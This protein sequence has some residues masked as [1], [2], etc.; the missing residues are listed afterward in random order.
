MMSEFSNLSPAVETRE[1]D[2]TNI[3]GGTG[4]SGGAYA[5]DFIWGPAK[6]VTLITSA[7]E[8]EQ[9]FGKPTDTNYA[10]WYSA[11]NFLAYSGDLRVVRA[12]DSTAINANNGGSGVLVE[13]D[14]HFEIVKTGADTSC[15]I[16]KYPGLLGNSLGVYA[17]DAATWATWDY[18]T[19]FDFAPGTS[20]Y[21]KSVGA[22]NDELHIVVV[23]VLGEFSGVVGSILEK[24]AFVSKAL[25]AKGPNNEPNF[26]VNVINR[27]SQYVRALRTISTG[28]AATTA[29]GKLGAF[30]I[31][32]S[33]GTGYATAPTVTIGA[34]DQLGGVQATAT[35]TL[36]AG[37][38]TAITLVEAGS[39]YSVAPTVTLTGGGFT[40]PATATVA[41][42]TVAGSAWGVNTVVAGVP[43]VFKALSA[44]LEQPLSG[45]ANSVSVG[46]AELMTALD[47][48]QNS[49]EVDVSLLFL[50]AAGG[51]S[52]HNTVVRYAIDNIAEYRQDVL[53]FFSPKLSD[54]MNKT[55]SQAVDGCLA[56][57]N[58][59]GSASS[60][61]VMD[62]GWKVQYDV[63][64][65]KFRWV[66]LNADV[67]GVCA[68]VDSTSDPW[69]SPG[70]YTKGQ[71]KNVTS[72]VFKPVKA[73]RDALYKVGI[74]PVVT[75][76]TDGTIL[77]GDK[78]LLGKNSAFS[79]IGVRRLFIVL[80][81]AVSSAAKYFLFDQNNDFT[82]A[83]F[84]NTVEP[85]LREVSG[86]GGI[87]A[88]RVV[89]DQ[90]NNTAQVQM[91]RQFIGDIYI[92][93]V[94]SIN[95]I[96][97]N[98]VAVRQDVAFEEKVGRVG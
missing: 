31:G 79:S 29:N 58:A 78:T 3:I 96:Q 9:Q 18:K 20:E 60:Y 59:I 61:A 28:L 45:G 72:L 77:F 11:F 98:F 54:I 33:G 6:E 91:A 80:R 34:P 97:L 74:N 76:N 22:V 71:I 13:N 82:R 10:D 1:V 17:A 93:P 48:F 95:W 14:K 50:G 38:V 43:T 40:T 24:Y 49:E 68:R 52:D 56:T 12:I 88:Y 86:R 69:I 65:D 25:D 90:T 5:G 27:T 30:T 81:K 73:S 15:F 67:A 32:G 37:V 42:D 35:A 51:D 57:R 62:S 44:K 2:L 21:A 47:L 36:T 46:A 89:C 92:K 26:Y 75:F 83:A 39:G 8:L 4:S 53:V 84:V 55:Q 85:Y 94:Y 7:L 19:Y 87:D 64:N 66:P 23:D 70:G 63:Y 16:A 41:L